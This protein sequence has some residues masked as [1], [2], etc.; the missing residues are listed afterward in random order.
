[1]TKP[2]RRQALLITTA[3]VPAMQ[4]ATAR[5]P[6]QPMTADDELEAARKVAARS[7]EQLAK[8]ELKADTEPAFI[9]RAY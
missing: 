2:T 9:F 8:V 6:A 5:P 1:M 4:Q 3:A 7:A